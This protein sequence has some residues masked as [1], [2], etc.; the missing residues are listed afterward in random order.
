MFVATL[1][2]APST[3]SLDPSLVENLR[4]AW[5][6]GDAQWLAPDEAAEF[7]L[8]QMPDNRW[9]V[10]ADLQQLGVDLVILPAEALNGEGSFIDN[11]PLDELTA[12]LAPA[13]IRTGYEITEALGSA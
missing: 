2:T 8:A 12:R 1:L 5:G 9:D 7:A 4:N 3:P 11:V 10:W 6:G 13:E